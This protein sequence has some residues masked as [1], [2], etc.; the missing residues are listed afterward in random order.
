MAYIVGKFKYHSCYEGDEG[1]VLPFQEGAAQS[2][3][4]GELVKLSSGKIIV[5]TEASADLMLGYALSDASGVTDTIISVQVIRPTDVFIVPY[6]SDD[7][8]AITDVGTGYGAKRT[9]NKWL[10]NQDN[11]TAAQVVFS[12]LGSLEYDARQILGA[13]A[14]GA[15]YVRFNPSN[16]QFSVDV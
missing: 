1:L 12:V 2:F 16:L 8:F 11:V 4:A 3:K 6:E 13:T 14:G 10:I 7:T 5:A 15:A 9:N